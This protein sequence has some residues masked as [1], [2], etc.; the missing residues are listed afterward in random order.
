[1][2]Y[3]RG[4]AD[5]PYCVFGYSSPGDGGSTVCPTRRLSLTLTPTRTKNITLLRPLA[6]SV[7]AK[8]REAVGGRDCQDRFLDKA[9]DLEFCQFRKLAC[10]SDATAVRHQAVR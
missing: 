8:G 6:A 7:P 3:V 5:G 10:I 1:M 2:G 9:T 4:D